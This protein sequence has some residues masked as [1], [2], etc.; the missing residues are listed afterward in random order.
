MPDAEKRRRA[1]YVV[2]SG[3]GRAVTLRR[4]ARIVRELKAQPSGEP[5]VDSSG[6]GR[7]GRMREI[8]VDTETTGLDPA[9][10]H[11]IVEL[12][13]VELSNHVPTGRAFH[14][15]VNPER[16]SRPTRLAVHGLTAE[17][18]AQHP[19][20]GAIVDEFLLFIAD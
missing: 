10:G 4:L 14:R 8:V 3:L 5:C 9:D 13:C 12:A 15:Y 6:S 20:F 2:P 18:L 7:V 19:P 17:Y 1:D 16:T 11:R